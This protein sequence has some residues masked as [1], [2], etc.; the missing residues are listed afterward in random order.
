MFS[1]SFGTIK[2]L[3]HLNNIQNYSQIHSPK[4]INTLH[5]KYKIILSKE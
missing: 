2:D 3:L 5:D 1:L 4:L